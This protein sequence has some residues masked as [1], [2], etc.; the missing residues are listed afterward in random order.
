VDLL[1]VLV[2]SLALVPVAIFAAEPLRIVLGLPFILFFPGYTLI[3]ALFPKRESISGIE[4][5]ALSFGL[6]IA[7]VPLIGLILNYTPWGIRL[8]PILIS[9]TVF[10][11]AMCGLAWYRRKRLPSDERFTMSFKIGFPSWKGQ[12]VV[13]KVLSVV[14]LLAIVG[15][16][17]MVIYVVATP[18]I[19]EKFTEFYVLG[20]QGKVGGYPTDIK[21]GDREEIILGIVNH[22]QEE[23]DYQVKVK[24]DGVEEGVRVQLESDNGKL[25]AVADN[26]IKVEGLAHEEEW[27]E[28]VVFEPLQRG[29]E[30]KLEFLLFSPKLREEYHI[31]SQLDSGTLIDIKMDEAEGKGSISIDN[32]SSA[33]RSYRL[34]VWQQG[35]VQGEVS[36]T[37]AADEKLERKLEFPSGE[38][39]FQLYENGELKLEDNGAELSL[40]LWLDVS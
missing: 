20:P 40:H 2:A 3:A 6:S 19:G 23:M 33:S 14:L 29:E 32:N 11:L 22:E 34:E 24:I 7:V 8:Y 5:I 16:I 9:L 31:R 30:Q 25:T 35:E 26:T 10:I 38:S 37:A 15:A 13:G 39:I 28:V 17:G 12:S 21:L 18:K 1:A 27:E 4:R 36:F